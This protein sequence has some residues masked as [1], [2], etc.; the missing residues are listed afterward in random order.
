[1][2]STIIDTESIDCNIPTTKFSGF[3]TNEQQHFNLHFAFTGHDQLQTVGNFMDS[4]ADADVVST[5]M[6]G[7]E[8]KDRAILQAVSDGNCTTWVALAQLRESGFA[9]DDNVKIVRC[10][11]DKI[12]KSK[13]LIFIADVPAQ[14]HELCAALQD[15]AHYLD[16]IDNLCRYSFE[17]QFD[18]ALRES[19]KLIGQFLEV[20]QRRERVIMQRLTEELPR[21]TREAVV[22]AHKTSINVT[23]SLGMGHSPML[24]GFNKAG[25]T[26]S[27]SFPNSI[28]FVDSTT[29][30]LRAMR[31][32]EHHR[33]SDEVLARMLL[34]HH[35]LTPLK[36]W[37]TVPREVTRVVSH[38]FSLDEIRTMFQTAS[39]DPKPKRIKAIATQTLANKGIPLSQDP[40]EWIS[41]VDSICK[42]R[43]WRSHVA[44]TLLSPLEK[45]VE[46][47][48]PLTKIE[49]KLRALLKR[50]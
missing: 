50:L 48:S 8:E 11:L 46:T 35:I 2:V 21:V 23:I 17:G 34:E 28:Q 25:F 29:T 15:S 3:M 41:Y 14:D 44:R 5:E 27:R 24:L 33:V 30:A 16:D 49:R 13:K 32:E 42:K 36:M 6:S 38:T 26:L 19:R 12:F 4:I 1:M 9:Y 43:R 20:H 39:T 22:T 45:Q 37:P 47:E 10:L 31:R 7:W 40:V 18:T